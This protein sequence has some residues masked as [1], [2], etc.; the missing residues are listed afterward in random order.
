MSLTPREPVCGWMKM[1]STTDVRSSFI[2]REREKL[3]LEDLLEN[4]LIDNPRR[5]SWLS[6]DGHECLREDRDDKLSE[7]FTYQSLWTSDNK[8]INAYIESH[9]CT[10]EIWLCACYTT[11]LNVSY[12]LMNDLQSHDHCIALQQLEVF[13]PHTALQAREATQWNFSTIFIFSPRSD[14]ICTEKKHNTQTIEKISENP[15]HSDLSL[16]S[17]VITKF[18]L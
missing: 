10:V 14:F 18:K 9:N 8:S 3:M 15:T 11:T 17:G 4:W 5:L 16:S 1:E 6:Q 7:K 2:A 13:P 12:E